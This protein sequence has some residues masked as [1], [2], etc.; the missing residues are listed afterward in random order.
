[1][2]RQRHYA[3]RHITA[4]AEAGKPTVRWRAAAAAFGGIELDQCYGPP[5][6]Q[7]AALFRLGGVRQKEGQQCGCDTH[8]PW[9]KWRPAAYGFG[10]PKLAWRHRFFF[11]APLPG[12]F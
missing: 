6:A 3:L 4:S 11:F 1:M 10:A 9:S 5:P 8:E 12:I 2:Q 7:S